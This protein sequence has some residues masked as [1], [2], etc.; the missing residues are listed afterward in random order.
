MAL[1]YFDDITTVFGGSAALTDT[2]AAAVL[3]FKPSETGVNSNFGAPETATAEGLILAL[4]Q[5]LESQQLI[6]T[7][8]AL[9][10]SKTAILATKGGLQVNGEQYI[11]RIFADS[12]IAP[13]DP[14]AVR[15][16]SS[17]SSSAG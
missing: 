9:E 8:R 15:A 2:G 1:T 6:T 16:T 14:D 4:L 17:S 7:D 10:I 5:R 11:I 13:L 12:S 3:S